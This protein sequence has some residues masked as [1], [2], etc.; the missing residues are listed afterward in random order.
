MFRVG[1]RVA[2]GDI[3]NDGSDF[4]FMGNGRLG[5]GVANPVGRLQLNHRSTIGNPA[6]L[7]LDSAQGSGNMISLRKEGVNRSFNIGTT[8]SE[9]GA[10]SL[11]FLH[12]DAGG[13]NAFLHYNANNNRV[14]INTLNPQATLD[15]GGSLRIIGVLIAGVSAGQP[16][17]VL[18][19][20]GPN[21]PAKWESL[22]DI[23]NSGRDPDTVQF[24]VYE[25]AS[26]QVGSGT[27]GSVI[28]I[29]G[30]ERFDITDKFTANNGLY[31]C[32]TAVYQFQARASF[33]A[34]TLDGPPFQVK[35]TIEFL[36]ND[37]VTLLRTAEETL[38]VPSGAP[39][40]TQFTISVSSLQS[41]GFGQKAR[42]RF[43]HNRGT[44]LPVKL[45]EFSG[46]NM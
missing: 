1:V 30:L 4:F 5:L 42:V 8:I 11:S 40:G 26:E 18:T 17:N 19:S 32:N 23:L 45:E 46:F 31:A 6:L 36:D 20:M 3:N 12:T 28:S 39:A 44:N 24:H 37:N 22:E 33:A 14:G 13:A 9:G 16:G 41:M 15:V 21:E 27:T 43:T 35:I 34:N 25:T 2:T 7:L 38:F 29:G 10:N